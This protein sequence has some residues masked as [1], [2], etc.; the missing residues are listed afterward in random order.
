MGP[1]PGSRQEDYAPG[2]VQGMTNIDLRRLRRQ[3]L[4]LTQVQLAIRLGVQ[5]VTV[6]RWE[7]GRNPIP[8]LAS[9]ALEL[10]AEKANRSTSAQQ[11]RSSSR[12][13]RAS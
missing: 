12:T 10:L 3:T 1:P 4:N 6:A 8:P 9:V 11:R 5:P 2:I 13:R 7:Q